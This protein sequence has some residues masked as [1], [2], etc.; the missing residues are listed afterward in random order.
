MVAQSKC[1]ASAE[2]QGK[3]SRLAAVRVRVMRGWNEGSKV[4]TTRKHVRDICKPSLIA[5]EKLCER[6]S[7]SS[8]VFRPVLI[9][10]G[11]AQEGNRPVVEHLGRTEVPTEWESSNLF[12]MVC[13]A[14]AQKGKWKKEGEDEKERV[15]SSGSGWPSVSCGCKGRVH[16]FRSGAMLQDEGPTPVQNSHLASRS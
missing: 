4:G 10:L 3:T 12:S 5:G 1:K 16:C 15:G 13:D 14:R 6:R 11:R 7:G 2:H 9:L 8:R